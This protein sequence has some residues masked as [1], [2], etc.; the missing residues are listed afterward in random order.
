MRFPGSFIWG[1]CWDSLLARFILRGLGLSSDCGCRPCSG[2]WFPFP[3]LLIGYYLT[4]IKYK[5]LAVVLTVIYA[6][7]AVIVFIGGFVYFLLTSPSEHDIGLGMICVAE[8]SG[9]YTTGY[10]YWDKISFFGRRQFE[11]DE[12]RDIRLLEDKYGM[13][14]AENSG[15]YVTEKYP[16]IAVHIL[17]YPTVS[18]SGLSDDFI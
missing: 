12:E 5:V 13:E 15:A 11:W 6:V 16:Q 10:T 1:A 9:G 4:R 17:G 18:G 14:F 7:L 3:A 8:Q 2:L